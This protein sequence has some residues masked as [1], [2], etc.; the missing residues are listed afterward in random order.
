MEKSVTKIEDKTL[1][2]AICKLV[3]KMGDKMVGDWERNHQ[4]TL[5][6]L[7]GGDYGKEVVAVDTDDYDYYVELG[8][9]TFT[10]LLA[11]SIYAT[12][13]S[14]SDIYGN[15]DTW[16]RYDAFNSRVDVVT[17]HTPDGASYDLDTPEA[18]AILREELTAME[19]AMN[20]DSSYY[21][22]RVREDMND[23]MEAIDRIA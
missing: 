19:Q 22:Q 18:I 8:D 2:L 4:G 16:T 9:L 11:V 21:E 1:R 20:G 6:E 5:E 14:E 23:L 10:G 17:V 15:C 12:P 7:H 13:E 3:D